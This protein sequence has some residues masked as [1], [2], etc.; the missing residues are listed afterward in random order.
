MTP[1]DAAATAQRMQNQIMVESEQV[2][3]SEVEKAKHS[4]LAYLSETSGSLLSTLTW[5]ALGGAAIYGLTLWSG[6][7]GPGT[8]GLGKKV[9]A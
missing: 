9:T 8:R 4:Q 7:L 6:V 1:Q 3:K 5:V 2:A